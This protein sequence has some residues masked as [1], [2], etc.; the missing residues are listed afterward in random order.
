MR[1]SSSDH[2][3]GSDSRFINL[4]V[5]EDG[6]YTIYVHCW[7]IYNLIVWALKTGRKASLWWVFLPASQQVQMNVISSDNVPILH[8]SCNVK[9]PKITVSSW[10]SALILLPFLIVTQHDDESSIRTTISW[11]VTV[12]NN[13]L[14]SQ[15]NLTEQVADM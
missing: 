3:I 9:K 6:I 2:S 14:S 11:S 15:C 10:T 1:L 13:N 8:F 12:Y 5:N 7:K 4:N